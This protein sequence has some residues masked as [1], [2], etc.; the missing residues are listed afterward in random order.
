MGNW[1]LL[2]F[3]A[4]ACAG[5]HQALAQVPITPETKPESPPPV[6]TE[7]KTP[8]EAHVARRHV[9]IF[10]PWNT[11]LT[12][13]G[14]VADFTLSDMREVS[15]VG[16]AWDVRVTFGTRSIVGVEV[17]YVGAYNPLNPDRRI[18]ASTLSP[19]LTQHG[20]D[21]DLR[22]NLLS[23]RVQPYVFGG[24]GYNHMIVSNRQDDPT[25]GQRFRDSDDQ[26]SVPSGAGLSGYFGRHTAVDV[27]FT[28]RA[29][30]ESNIDMTHPN[31]RADQYQVAGRLGYAF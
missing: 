27:R 23:S 1:R 21:S 24:L 3:I 12:V 20:L 4:A 29:I 31:G 17:A 18:A 15:R 16:A 22:I 30:F 28:Y 10:S 19:F 7:Q 5:G 6:V 2:A 13:G 26:L 25:L 8:G 14:G 9:P 11:A